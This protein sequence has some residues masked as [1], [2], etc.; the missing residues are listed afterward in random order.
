M[1]NHGARIRRVVARQGINK[2]EEFVDH[3]LSLENL[4]DL[5][6]PFSGKRPK[7]V[8]DDDE[9][10]KATE[11]PRL[12]SKDYMESFINPD[13]YLEEQRKKIEAER[14]KT[15]KFPEH[16]ERDVLLV[17]PRQRA[18]RALGA[19]RARGDPRGGLLLRRRSG[20]RRS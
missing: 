18:A 6:A 10:P 16:P 8:T 5:H 9:E 1:A 11:I 17:P 14:E 19:R 13:E 3:C 20:R 2:V 7:R 4:I 15:K 12:R